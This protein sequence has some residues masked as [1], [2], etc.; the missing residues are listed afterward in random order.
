MYVNYAFFPG[1]TGDNIEFLQQLNKKFVPGIKLFMG[2]ST[3]DMLVNDEKKLD[4]IFRVAKE[5]ELPLMVHCEDSTKISTNLEDLVR[6]LSSEELSMLLHS[7]LRSSETCINSTDLAIK[8]AKKHKTRLHI[9]HISTKEELGKLTASKC[10]YITGEVTPAYLLFCTDDYK[11]LGAK[12]KCN[13]ALKYRDDRDALR[14]ALTKNKHIYTIGSDHAPHAIE[15]K[16]GGSLIALSGIPSIQ[17]ILP[18]MLELAEKGIVTIERLVG[19]M[20]H[21]P[22]Q[23][24]SVSQRGYLRE[25]YKADLA[26]LKHVKKPYRVNAEDVQSKCC[27]SPFE[28]KTGTKK[29]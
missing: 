15:E 22:A 4:N 13:P 27:W 28:G 29:Q 17:F 3:G 9:A 24:F 7:I 1:A 19:L 5:L 25:G 21:H 26:I 11:K 16:Q 23:L 18:A 14:Q 2:A 12:I 20:C 6:E 10:N 8:L